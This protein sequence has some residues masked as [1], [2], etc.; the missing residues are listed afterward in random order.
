MHIS[1]CG[2]AELPALTELYRDAFP[3]E[4][5]VPLIKK[6]VGHPSTSLALVAK[7]AGKI[8][9][10]IHYSACELASTKPVLLGPLAI[11]SDHQRQGVGTALIRDA[12][13]KLD[14][15]GVS[16]IVVLGDP[17]YYGRHGFAAETSIKP[18]YDLPEEWAGAW[19]SLALGGALAP[20]GTLIVPEPWQDPKLWGA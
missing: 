13:S 9:G 7:K 14:A 6:L 18:P 12:Q 4:D 17:N 16:H 19:Q 2:T 10:H 3:D 1:A 20:S 11:A 5:L 8:I 15:A